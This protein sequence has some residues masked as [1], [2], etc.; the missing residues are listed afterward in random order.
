MFNTTM[1]WLIPASF[2]I[3][4]AWAPWFIGRLRQYKVGKQIR[5]DGPSSHAV[6]AGTPTMGGWIMV[7]TTIGLTLL[8]LR[9]WKIALPLILSLLLFAVY[10]A[11][12][13]FANLRSQEGLG[14][15]VRYKFLWHNAM[16]LVIAAAMFFVS[17]T[18][19]VAVPLLG[20]F[21][22][23]WW[24]IPLAMLT[25]FSTT[26]GVNEID[27]LD[28]LAGGTTALAYAA[29]LVI[30]AINGQVQ[31]AAFCA[32]VLG[33]ILAFLWFNVH[34]ARVFMGDTGS[35]ALGAGLAAAALL[36][37][38][39]LLLPVIGFVFVVELVS[40]IVQVAYFKATKGKRIFKMSPLHHHFELSGWP[41]VQ[42]VQRFW[43]VAGLTAVIGIFLAVI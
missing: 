31:V 8:F 2:I 26:S 21:E 19:A 38:W 39:V 22:I 7:A 9:D 25:I 29:F 14:L 37:N 10:G 34:P 13:D 16:A 27:G 11:V 12:D 42:I 3:A 36:T 28:G 43:I 15:R 40:V 1:I 6:K 23:G 35:L 5:V 18:S 20:Q 17:G 24:F 30:A 41:E 4:L 32:I 33:S